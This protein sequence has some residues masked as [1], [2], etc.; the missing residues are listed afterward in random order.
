MVQME[1]VWASLSGELSSDLLHFQAWSCCSRAQS[2]RFLTGEMEEIT[3]LLLWILQELIMYCREC[4]KNSCAE[5]RHLLRIQEMLTPS[6][7]VSPPC[8]AA[9]L[10]CFQALRV[11]FCLICLRQALPSGLGWPWTQ[12]SHASV[13]WTEQQACGTM[14]NFSVCLYWCSSYPVPHI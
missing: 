13:S 3:L 9:L 10:S 6:S 12:H 8:E 1:R 14:P 5:P 2:I 4:Y 7:V 11:F